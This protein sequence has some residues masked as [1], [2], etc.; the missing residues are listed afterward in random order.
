MKYSKY[1]SHEN[2]MDKTMKSKLL[3]LFS[4]V[5]VFTVLASSQSFAQDTLT[6]SEVTYKIEADRLQVMHPAGLAYVPAGDAFILLGARPA[7]AAYDGYTLYEP[8]VN[9]ARTLSG[10]P[11]IESPLNMAYDGTR[12]RLLLLD[13][14]ATEL[15]AAGLAAITSSSTNS[16]YYNS[17]E[18]G[19]NTPVLVIA[20]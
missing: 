4:L 13:A 20:Q 14:A 18:A 8:A 10:G 15:V 12:E 6:V 17:K 9:E 5:L 7:G 3:P 1:S 16:V 19:G 2:A 11:A